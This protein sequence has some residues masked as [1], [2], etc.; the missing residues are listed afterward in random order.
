MTASRRG[1][2]N[3]YAWVKAYLSGTHRTVLQTVAWVV[4]CLLVAQRLT[5]AALARA[6]GASEKNI[7]AFLAGTPTGS[8]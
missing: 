8:R 6:I 1:Y 4:L 2:G 7:P 5:P 3:G